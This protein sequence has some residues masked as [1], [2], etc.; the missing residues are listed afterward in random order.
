MDSLCYVF[1]NCLKTPHNN[2]IVSN[3]IY[4]RTICVCSIV[5]TTGGAVR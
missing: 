3:T 2:N 1:I 4:G 5:F